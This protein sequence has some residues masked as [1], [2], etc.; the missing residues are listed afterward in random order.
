[1]GVE[2]QREIIDTMAARK[3]LLLMAVLL[4]STG[5]LSSDQTSLLLAL[6]PPRYPS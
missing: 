2:R 1:L 6:L 4:L 5:K 3:N